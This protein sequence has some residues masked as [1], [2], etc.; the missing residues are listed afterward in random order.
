MTP[1]IPPQIS[2]DLSPERGSDFYK[3]M[4]AVRNARK[5]SEKNGEEFGLDQED[6]LALWTRCQGRCEVTGIPFEYEKSGVKHERRPYA[7]SLDRI[8]SSKGYIVDNVRVVCV[9]VNLAMNQWGEKVLLN[10]AISILRRRCHPPIIYEMSKDGSVRH[11]SDEEES[12][13]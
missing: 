6:C 10:I 4:F 2:P 12:L 11:V 7:P 5:R 8:E 1:P 9:A 3:F 13:Y